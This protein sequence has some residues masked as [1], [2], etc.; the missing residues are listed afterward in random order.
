M[1]VEP[2]RYYYVICHA[3]HHFIG[4]LEEITGKRE[5]TFSDVHWIYSS[6]LSWTDFFAKGFTKANSKYHK[7][8]DG[9]YPWTCGIF[10][11][12]HP[13]PKE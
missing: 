12:N 8:P 6:Q 2:G 13:L 10:A 9:N 5:G 3:Y 1:K 7:F 4:K 11:W